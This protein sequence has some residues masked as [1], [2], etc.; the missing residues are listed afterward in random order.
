MHSPNQSISLHTK[1]DF[2]LEFQ[3]QPFFFTRIKTLRNL[4]CPPCVG[5]YFQHSWASCLFFNKAQWIE[6]ILK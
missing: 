6:N 1:P 5:T 3:L 2:L 4:G